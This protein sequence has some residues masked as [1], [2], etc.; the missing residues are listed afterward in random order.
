MNAKVKKKDGVSI[1]DSSLRSVSTMLNR[2]INAVKV[3][4]PNTVCTNVQCTVN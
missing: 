2:K 4:W 1:L 3:S